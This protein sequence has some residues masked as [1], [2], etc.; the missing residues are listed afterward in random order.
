MMVVYMVT[1]SYTLSSNEISLYFLVGWKISCTS[2]R[3]WH[4]SS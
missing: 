1:C 4:N 3:R 2:W